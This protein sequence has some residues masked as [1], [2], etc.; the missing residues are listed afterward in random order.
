MVKQY[1]SAIGST[2]CWK[3]TLYNLNIISL[4]SYPLLEINDLQI[5]AVVVRED[6]LP[7]ANDQVPV[8]A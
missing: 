8:T 5:K 2:V 7:D 3:S 1:N 4:F 6:Y